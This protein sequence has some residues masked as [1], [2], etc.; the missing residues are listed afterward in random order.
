MTPFHKLIHEALLQPCLEA[1]RFHREPPP[2]KS[3]AAKRV[4]AFL[5]TAVGS[6]A[7]KLTPEALGLI[8]GLAQAILGEPIEYGRKKQTIRQLA[9]VV[10]SEGNY[11]IVTGQGLLLDY[12][13]NEMHC[14]KGLP[15]WAS[16]AQVM[17]CLTK[18]TA[19][20]VFS[21]MRIKAFEKH[22]K[23][24]V[25]SD[26]DMDAIEEGSMRLIIPQENW[27]DQ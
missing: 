12:S 18:L 10:V 3:E 6:P 2:I 7:N 20:Q 13:G 19:K 24:L 9:V 26:A 1:T 5:Q 17:E 16:D 15:D 14:P 21:M 22:V 11:H 25:L 4:D 8:A 27:T 23:P